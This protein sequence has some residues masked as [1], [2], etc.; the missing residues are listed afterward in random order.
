MQVTVSNGIVLE[1]LLTTAL[2]FTISRIAF[3]THGMVR[4][5]LLVVC[6]FPCII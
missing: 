2:V 3:D 4:C 6:F 1:M 5:L